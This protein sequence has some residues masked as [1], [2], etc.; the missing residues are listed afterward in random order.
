MEHIQAEYTARNRALEHFERTEKHHRQEEFR[1]IRTNIS[2]KT[3]DDA[4]YHLQ[5]RTLA[6]TEK[7]LLRDATFHTWLE[8]SES[9]IDLLWLLGIPG[10]GQSSR[11]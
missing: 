5:S 10:A 7:W 1:S 6:G 8:N 9:S 3:Y 2:P 4:M 11:R